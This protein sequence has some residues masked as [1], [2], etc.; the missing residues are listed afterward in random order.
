MWNEGKGIMTIGKSLYRSLRSANHSM[1]STSG[2]ASLLR[3][4]RT[5]NVDLLA[6]DHS[7]GSISWVFSNMSSNVLT[8]GFRGRNFNGPAAF[9]LSSDQTVL[10][11]TD[12]VNNLRN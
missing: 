2:P 4:P 1:V 6:S 7:S 11:F 12:P 3:L 5:A 8:S 9:A 10:F